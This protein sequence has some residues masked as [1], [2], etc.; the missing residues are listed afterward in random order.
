MTKEEYLEGIQEIRSK[1]AELQARKNELT[2]AYR[3]DCQPCHRGDIIR[4]SYKVEGRKYSRYGMVIDENFLYEDGDFR[5]SLVRINKEGITDTRIYYD[6]KAPIKIKVLGRVPTCSEC[7]WRALEEDKMYCNITTRTGA[8]GRYYVDE[9]RM[10]CGR[11]CYVKWKD[12]IPWKQNLLKDIKLY[13]K[14]N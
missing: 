12:G 6:G 3:R 9:E 11:G 5:P 8:G 13:E 1:Y 10:M 4:I 7:L 2:E 14:R